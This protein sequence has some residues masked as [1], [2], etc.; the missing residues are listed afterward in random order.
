MKIWFYFYLSGKIL[1]NPCEKSLSLEQTSNPVTIG[2][3]IDSPI[4]D[5]LDS[6]KQ[7]N[8]PHT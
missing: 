8:K 5:V 7:I 3:S 2:S 1:K 4:I 6:F